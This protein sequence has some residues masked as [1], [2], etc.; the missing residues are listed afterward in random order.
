MRINKGTRHHGDCGIAMGVQHAQVCRGARTHDRCHRTSDQRVELGS[1]YCNRDVGDLNT[2]LKWLAQHN[3]FDIQRPE[4]R[5]LSS[6]LTASG[7]DGVNCDRSQK[8]DSYS[9]EN[10]MTSNI[11][12]HR[13]KALRK[14]VTLINLTKGIKIDQETVHVEPLILFSRLLALLE[15]CEDTT[16]YFQYELTPFPASLFKH[17]IMRKPNKSV[18]GTSLTSGV[19]TVITEIDTSYVLDGGALLHRVRWLGG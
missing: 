5:S 17:S 18:L 1:I 2:I 8:L 15:R 13:L 10:S 14:S 11:T 4:L 7:G 19:T 6:G 16:P 12:K 9:K 3:P